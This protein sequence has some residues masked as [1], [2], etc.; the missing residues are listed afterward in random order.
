MG[1]SV[2][3]E[4]LELFKH[5]WFLL[6]DMSDMFI[7]EFIANGQ[8]RDVYAFAMDPKYVVKI[9]RSGHFN[10]VSEWD[11]WI[12]SPEEHKRFLAPCLKISQCGRLLIQERTSPVTLE[13]MPEVI[14]GFF[15]DT[16]LQNWGKI[17]D[18][19]VCHDYA[20]HRFYQN[21]YGK[22][23]PKWW[24]DN[25]QVIEKKDEVSEATKKD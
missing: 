16:K 13:E 20:N 17:G 19:I 5:D 11:V 18:N 12:N 25:F 1:A 22:I 15:T 7:G 24:S 10:N 4:F 21:P 2:N 9:D 23:R 8:S 3:L 6:A 14:P